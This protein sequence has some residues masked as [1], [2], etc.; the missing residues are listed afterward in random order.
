M[1]QK[2][3]MVRCVNSSCISENTVV[4]GLLTYNQLLIFGDNNEDLSNWAKWYLPDKKIV[5]SDVAGNV[6]SFFLYK[7]SDSKEYIVE[8]LYGLWKKASQFPVIKKNPWE[9]KKFQKLLKKIDFEK[10]T[11]FI[12]KAQ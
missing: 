4:G 1:V 12:V 5:F 8:Y 6:V 3:L 9:N 11:Y 10:A 2:M 7:V